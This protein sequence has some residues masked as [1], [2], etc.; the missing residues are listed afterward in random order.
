MK[1]LKNLAAA[2]IAP[3]ESI[4]VLLDES[5]RINE[6]GS[7]D[8]YHARRNERERMKSEQVYFA[9]FPKQEEIAEEDRTSVG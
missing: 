2:I 9:H 8:N 1:L 5:R 6:D 3:F 4:A 7:W